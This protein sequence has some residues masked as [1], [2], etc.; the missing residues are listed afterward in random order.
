MG[1]KDWIKRH[2]AQPIPGPAEPS[3]QNCPRVYATWD[4]PAYLPQ[5]GEQ[6]LNLPLDYTDL[7]MVN[8]DR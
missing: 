4:H 6:Q 3:F 8:G 2:G 5:L 1:F 7:N